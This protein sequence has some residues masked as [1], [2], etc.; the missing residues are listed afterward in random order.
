MTSMPIAHIRSLS[1]L[2]QPWHYALDVNGSNSDL[3]WKIR[4]GLWI[5]EARPLYRDGI[6]EIM[7]SISPLDFTHADRALLCTPYHN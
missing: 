7:A 5:P 4:F 3:Y 6:L 1:V 2:K